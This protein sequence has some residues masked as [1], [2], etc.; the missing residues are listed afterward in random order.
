MIKTNT[1]NDEKND[2]HTTKIMVIIYDYKYNDYLFLVSRRSRKSR[3]MG[4]IERSSRSLS[5]I[6][7]ASIRMAHTSD[8]DVCFV[9]SARSA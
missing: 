7:D 2:I 6:P 4:C 3:R 9:R 8:S 1:T 5:A